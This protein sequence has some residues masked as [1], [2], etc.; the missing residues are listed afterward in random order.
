MHGT[1]MQNIT[2]LG[3]GASSSSEWGRE[4]SPKASSKHSSPKSL[5][6]N[7]ILAKALT[8]P[9]PKPPQSFFKAFQS[10]LQKVSCLLEINDW[11]WKLELRVSS[12][13]SSKGSSEVLSKAQ[14]KTP[15]KNLVQ[16]PHSQ[17]LVMLW[18]SSKEVKRAQV[19]VFRS[20]PWT[21]IRD[22][23]KSSFSSFF[24]VIKALWVMTKLGTTKTASSQL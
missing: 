8:K 3:H 24:L 18:K 23:A 11:S 17:S 12:R 19:S 9:R 14:P 21:A 13:S 20:L 5:I 16:R 2:S 22:L 15:S 10:H 1:R 4:I 7:L 6:Q